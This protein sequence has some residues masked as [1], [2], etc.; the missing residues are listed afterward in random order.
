MTA[1]K[2]AECTYATDNIKQLFLNAVM[3]SDVCSVFM[4]TAYIVITTK[5]QTKLV[6]CTA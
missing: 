6:Y 2:K 5:L 4:G 3:N 1:I